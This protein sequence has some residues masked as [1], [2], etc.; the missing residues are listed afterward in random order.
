MTTTAEPKRTTIRRA[1][2]RTWRRRSGLSRRLDRLG[3]GRPR[4][5]LGDVHRPALEGVV[6]RDE[7]VVHV[8]GSTMCG[9]E[10]C[11]TLIFTPDGA[12]F[13]RVATIRLTHAPIRVSSRSTSGWRN[14]IVS[15]SAGATRQRETELRYDGQSYPTDPT[16]V[17]VRRWARLTGEVI[18]PA[19]TE[20]DEA[21]QSIYQASIT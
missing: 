19:N 3:V 21:I 2:E 13:R 20:L 14:L 9:P 6:A 7:V 4:V 18:V 10:G 5:A 8:V 12:D 11:E 1:A 17:P 15:V 16:T